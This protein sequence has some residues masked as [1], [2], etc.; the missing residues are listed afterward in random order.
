ME[1]FI[2]IWVYIF[3]SILS[4]GFGGYEYFWPIYWY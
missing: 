3:L 1:W 4:S 2:Y